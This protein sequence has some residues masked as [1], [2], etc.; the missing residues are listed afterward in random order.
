[1]N[2]AT[3]LFLR[4]NAPCHDVGAARVDW[5]TLA[6]DGTKLDGDSNVALDRLHD[7]NLIARDAQTVVLVPG[8][9][10]LFHNLAVPA[11]QK[12][13][14]RQT[15]PYLMEEVIIEP[16]EDMHVAGGRERAGKYPVLALSHTRM[17]TWL[18]LLRE[19]GITPDHMIADT[20]AASLSLAETHVLFDEEYGIISTGA[21]ALKTETGNIGLFLRSYISR[22]KDGET[23]VNRIKF[24]V[25]PAALADAQTSAVIA[26]T[27]TFLET[28]GITGTVDKIDNTF[29]YLCRHLHAVYTTGKRK[30][31]ADL[32]QGP[33]R[34][35]R[36]KKQQ[37]NWRLLA[38]AL[39]VAAGLKV[40]V[41][42]ATG[43]YLEYELAR[44]DQQ[45]TALYRSLFPEDEKIINVRVQMEQHLN[46]ALEPKPRAGFLILV[47]MLGRQLSAMGK[48]ADM[49][50]QQL[51]YDSQQ[52]A[53]WLDI[54]I[55]DIQLLDQLKQGMENQALDVTILSVNTEEQWIKGQLRIKPA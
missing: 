36:F 7:I 49:Q 22:Y 50:I 46:R 16:V 30:E 15:L 44:L 18:A 24:I 19:H 28:K 27:T 45:V 12:R 2:R 6:Q 5:F 35:H 20:Y 26:D 31:I 48:L 21:T 13:Y 53:L 23:P 10:I 25:T 3:M 52:N 17:R 9:G 33:Y 42:L 55:K 39:L 47:G 32:I 41:D 54:R 4:I 1:M 51:R 37:L 40:V 8:E 38:A 11:G 14:L 34:V 43:F 29:E